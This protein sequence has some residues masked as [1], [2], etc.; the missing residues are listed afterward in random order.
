VLA[1]RDANEKL[2]ALIFNR[3]T[4]TIGAIAGHRSPSF[5]GLAARKSKPELGGAVCFLEGASGSRTI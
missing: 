1:F 2:R 5:Y 3:S 4:H